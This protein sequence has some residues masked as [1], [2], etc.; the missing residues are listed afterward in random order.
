MNLAKIQ[1]KQS[2]DNFCTIIIVL[3][4]LIRVGKPYFHDEKSTKILRNQP[5]P[6]TFGWYIS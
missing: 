2:Y 4:Y 6:A 5:K 1:I 3:Q